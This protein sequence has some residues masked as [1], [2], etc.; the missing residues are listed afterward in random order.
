[1]RYGLL[2]G[3]FWA[4][5]TVFLGIVL[6]SVLPSEKFL[7]II[8][9]IPVAGAFLHDLFSSIWLLVITLIRKKLTQLKET[10]FT[11]NG[12]A[13][14]LA[15]CL[16]GPVGMTGYVLAIKYIGPG[17]TACISAFYPAFGAILSRIFLKD[18]LIPLQY[19]SFL[20]ALCGVMGMGYLS[21]VNS[22][23]IN[24]TLGLICAMVCVIGWG[25]EAVLGSY[26][27][28]HKYID[29]QIA[30]QIRNAISAL[31]YAMLVIPL[32][33]IEELIFCGFEFGNYVFTMF[34]AAIGTISYLF[35][36]KA[37]EM[38]GA[39]RAMALNISY[40]A[41]ALLFSVLILDYSPNLYEVLCCLL[42]IFGAIF[43]SHSQKELKILNQ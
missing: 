39:S 16:G 7:N 8:W 15:A 32:L 28:R 35:Y 27:M 18:R 19:C 13:I 1:M 6:S 34:C 43:S 24:S 14:I 21:S 36:Y 31:V 37:I 33:G 30:L 2:S 25:S 10:I 3:M 29:N 26:A 12:Y 20:I 11:S 22:V 42:I 38:I 41:W 9:L 23:V 5:D 40:S 17:Y 4:L